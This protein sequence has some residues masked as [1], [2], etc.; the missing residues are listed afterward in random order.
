MNL[1]NILRFL[2]G[3]VKITVE[4]GFIERFINLSATNNIHIWSFEPQIKKVEGYVLAK[5]FKRLRSIARKSGVKLRVTQKIGLPFYLKQHK[6][7]SLLILGIIFFFAYI[8]VMNQ[9][10]W[11][12]EV[13]GTE[14]VSH[15]QILNVLEQ[16][17]LRI[18]A[19][20]PTL[21]ET[22]LSR[23]GVNYFN[24][25]LMWM[26]VN[27]KGSKAVIEVRDYVDEHEDTTFGDPCNIIADFEGTVLSAEIFNG[28]QEVKVGSAVKKGD[29]LIS[30][31][32]QNR[33]LSADYL[34]ARGKITALHS[35]NFSKTYKSDF[36]DFLSFSKQKNRFRLNFLGVSIPLY[37][38]LNPNDNNSLQYDKYMTLNNTSLPFGVTVITD[39]ETE[40]SKDENSAL[41]RALDSYVKDY[42]HNFRNTNI[43]D[44]KTTVTKNGDGFI[45][46]SDLSC[47][48]FMGTKSLI[49]IDNE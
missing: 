45:I 29:L 25:R 47:I 34:E 6:N 39:T 24:G 41:L 49:Y 48:D 12:T 22:A 27:I 35:V 18:G 40:Y 42:Y 43:L 9:F 31:V 28:D 16:Y 10:V 11:Y 1:I 32:I 20:S 4:G 8:F 44:F 7:R 33:D 26:S 23:N 13:I 36:N 3:Y 21:D 46:D 17:G 38:K 37:F 30:G 2:R 5:N 19:F 14:T 15:E